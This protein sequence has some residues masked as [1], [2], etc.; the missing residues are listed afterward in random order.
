MTGIADGK[1]AAG[2]EECGDDRG[3]E[4]ARARQRGELLVEQA[5][6]FGL[7]QPIDEAPHE[8][9]QIGRG[10]GDRLAVSRDVG[11]QQAG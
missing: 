2:L 1:A 3:G 8:R 4:G 10:G 7:I 9:A 11:Q 6:E 5:D